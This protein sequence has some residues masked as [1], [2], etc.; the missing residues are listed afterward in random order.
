MISQ[1]PLVKK[2]EIKRYLVDFSFQK[3]DQMIL[4]GLSENDKAIF[5]KLIKNLIP[6]LWKKSH[7]NV[8]QEKLKSVEKIENV[9]DEEMQLYKYDEYILLANN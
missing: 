2:N 7:R 1:K 9:F 4:K 5:G 3:L 6:I 8:L